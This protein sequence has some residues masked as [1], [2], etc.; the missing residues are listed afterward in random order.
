MHS[1][2][3]VIQHFY[4]V[5][6]GVVKTYLLNHIAVFSNN[7][8]IFEPWIAFSLNGLNRK[9][10]PMLTVDMAGDI[11]CHLRRDVYCHKC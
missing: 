10:I 3:W 1:I 5:A 11:D 6:Y 7:S 8:V 2:K 4:T 9:I